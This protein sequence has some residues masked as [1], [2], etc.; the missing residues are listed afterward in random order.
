MTL[1]LAKQALK[2]YFGYD[3]FR[4]MQEEIVETIY[5]GNDA[6]VLMPTGGGKSICFQIPAITMEGCCVVVSPLISLM[7]DQV[8][9]LIANGINAAYLNSSLS[10]LEQQAVEND[11]FNN[12]ID[13]LYVSPEKLV[14]GD[15]FPLLQRAKVNLFAIDEAHCISSWGHDF[16]PEYTKMKF[17]KQQFPTI[18]IIA[19]TATAD[20]LTR[21]DILTQMGIP[22]AKTFVASF[23]RPNLSLEIRPGQKRMEQ[24]I[25][26]VKARK[27]ESGIV[28]CLSRKNTEQVASKLQGKGIKAMC[29][30]AGMPSKVR[31]D[32]QEDF[33]ND[34]IPVVCAT[35][36]FGMGIDKSNVRW[37][38]HYNLPKN[39]ESYYQEIGRAGRDGV[40]ADTLMFYS[41]RDV[42][43]YRDMFEEGGG[44]NVEVK[45]SKLE[46][47]QQYAEA[48]ICRRKILLNYFN[49]NLEEDCG[50]C[51]VCKD[52]PQYINGTILAQKALSAVARLRESVGIRMLIDVLR[53]SGRRE[54]FQNGFDKIKTYGAGRE[55]SFGD[56]QYFIQQLINL[57]FLEIAYDQK[58]ALKLTAAS[59][60]VL[61]E[62][63]TVQL[64]QLRD[65]KAER[66]AAKIKF[67]PKSQKQQ[68]IDDL[69]EVLR[70][71]RRTLAQQQ[72]VPPYLIFNDATLT[73]I[74]ETRPT[75]DA[76][77]SQISGVGERKLARYGDQFMDAIITFIKKKTDE[78]MR[79]TGSTYVLTHQLLKEGLSPTEIAKKR[80][81]NAITVFSHLAYLYEKGVDIDIHQY[82]SEAE[83]QAILSTINSMKPPFTLS[84]VHEKMKGQVEYHQIR[85]AMAHQS[86]IAKE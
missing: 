55:Q 53:G 83:L 36:A 69:F 8:E 59:R 72:G 37:V 54:I 2:K 60:A 31:S 84:E 81:I 9:G 76:D 38:I 58:N 57:G 65:K 14:S 29:Y 71:L 26:F 75:T 4:P 25:E 50:N 23:D 66:E 85:L 28:Y 15:F 47:M 21:K 52:P 3:S 22:D 39:L 12:N 77:F 35:V 74:A 51:D 68:L 41:Y 78:G 64:V 17:I 44:D 30:H 82:V 43:V 42:M 33:I 10:S 20:K 40:K 16:R 46:R 70:E 56:W 79:V 34:R 13:L 67:K 32:V 18:P 24:I 63:K 6:L 19:L 48:L 5:A 80:N 45:L 1:T 61:F 7:K 86:K 27:N 11:L 73:E 62:K 49:E